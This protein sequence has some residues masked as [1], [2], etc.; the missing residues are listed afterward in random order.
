MLADRRVKVSTI[1]YEMSVSECSVIRIMHNKLGMS[2]VSCRWVPQMLT[3]LQ[4]QS[5]VELCCEKICRC[6]KRTWKL[7]A[8]VLSLGTKYGFIT[9][10]PLQ[11]RSQ[12]NGSTRRR[13]RQSNFVSNCLPARLLRQ[14]FGTAMEFYVL[15]IWHTSLV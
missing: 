2:K 5:H 10:I 15:N 9:G 11:S 7:S 13:R 12:C 8:H 4:K 1:A 6:M 3:P 14:C